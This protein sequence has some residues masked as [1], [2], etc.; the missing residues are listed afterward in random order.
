MGGIIRAT[1][2]YL[3]NPKKFAAKNQKNTLHI[4]NKTNIKYVCKLGSGIYFNG[5]YLTSITLLQ[6][7]TNFNKTLLNKLGFFIFG[8]IIFSPVESYK[9]FDYVHAN[10]NPCDNN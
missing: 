9:F 10:G 7:L 2:L 5:L 8:S 1:V 6:P 4:V 3:K